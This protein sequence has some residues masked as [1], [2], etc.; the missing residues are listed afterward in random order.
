[1]GVASLE[2]QD[3]FRVMYIC[4]KF[5][6]INTQQVIFT[7]VHMQKNPFTYYVPSAAARYSLIIHE[8]LVGMVCHT[9]FC[10]I[11]F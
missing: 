5:Q 11:F 6:G 9:I 8:E 2:E 3:E 10:D 4:I 1:M 7:M